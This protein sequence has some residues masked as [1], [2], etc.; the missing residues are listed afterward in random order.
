VFAKGPLLVAQQGN[1][2]DFP[3]W[4][5]KLG[6]QDF[7]RRYPLKQL[8]EWG[9]V[10]P[11]FRVVFPKEFFVSWAIFP[12][13]GE[14]LPPESHAH[15]LLWDS[16]WK[17]DS[18]NEAHWF[19]HLFFHPENEVRKLLVEHSKANLSTPLPEE[20]IHPNGQKVTPY[21]DFFYHWQGYALIDVI[22]SADCI[23]PIINTPDVEERA[24]G[25]VRVAQFAKQSDPRNVLK[26]DSR[27]GGLAEVMTWLS[28]YRA[29][30]DAIP[31]FELTREGHNKIRRKGAKE[32]A[33]HLGISSESLSIAIKDRLL[34][35]AQEWL[36]ANEKYCAWTLRAWPHLQQDI[37]IAMEW[38]C[39]LS[40]RKLDSYLEQWRYRDGWKEGWAQLCDVLPHEFFED[41][42]RFLLLTPNYF[43]TYNALLP[44]SQ[45]LEGSVL[46]ATVD[47][48]RSENYPFSSFI[49][50][51][52][53]LHD[54]LSSRADPSKGLLDFRELRPLDYYSLLAIRA[55][56]AL[57]YAIDQDPQVAPKK[58]DSLW[59][60]IAH[61]AT[62][63]GLS[64]QAINYFSKEVKGLSRLHD[65]PQDPIGKIMALNPGC[66]DR[67]DHIIKAFLCCTLARNYFAHH[68]YLDGQDLPR[69]MKSGFLLSG[70]L[71]TVL[72]LL[73]GPAEHVPQNA[74]L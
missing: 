64:Q 59:K 46:A 8:V 27:W 65:R 51:F 43:K 68:N 30:R 23:A 62:T 20:F 58:L 18:D 5:E 45:R 72:Y 56:Q 10:V 60:Y 14:K 40:G 13:L 3:R 38:L 42:E 31:W 15:S 29:F 6:L 54:E 34:V 70:I 37:A 11:Q 25:V 66:G 33:K 12:C 53:Q 71:L 28:H 16:S 4:L 57:R 74:P 73:S 7:V 26:V 52:R 44:E 48:I 24:A 49:G 39:Y 67:E 2:G 50:A 22:R 41:R 19:L 55:E 61:F 32:L 36:W 21:A 17:I 63:C 9:W 69:S 47:R 1:E 35:L